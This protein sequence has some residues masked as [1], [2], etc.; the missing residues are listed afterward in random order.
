MN[1]LMGTVFMFMNRSRG[2]KG[3]TYPKV[4]KVAWKMGWRGTDIAS[5]GTFGV[6]GTDIYRYLRFCSPI[7][8][9]VDSCKMLQNRLGIGTYLL[10]AT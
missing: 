5:F 2:T 3:A 6:R 4:L 9:F 1:E 8:D 10:Y 7:A